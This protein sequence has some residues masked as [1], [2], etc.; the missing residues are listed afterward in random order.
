MAKNISKRADAIKTI[1]SVIE[2]LKTI[3]LDDTETKKIQGVGIASLYYVRAIDSL[4]KTADQLTRCA[5][6]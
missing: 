1:N 4:E 6:W 3:K 5:E 2:T